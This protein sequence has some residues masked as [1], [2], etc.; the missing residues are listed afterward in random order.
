M[1]DL[2]VGKKRG[3]DD[4]FEDLQWEELLP[5]L[6][7]SKFVCSD[8]LH[9]EPLQS[10]GAPS[11]PEEFDTF[12]DAFQ[13]E[14]AASLKVNNHKEKAWCSLCKTTLSCS[15]ALGTHILKRHGKKIPAIMNYIQAVRGYARTARSCPLCP[16]TCYCLPARIY[17]HLSDEHL[18]K[19]YKQH[20]REQLDKAE[21]KS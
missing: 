18:E 5:D 3:I 13:K 17:Q 9:S 20:N 6:S 8:D 19:L 11:V 10:T 7:P 2:S 21:N 16:K 15:S 4:L 1:E 12:W 14:R